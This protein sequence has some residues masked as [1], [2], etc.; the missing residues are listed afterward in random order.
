MS[1]VTVDL[2]DGALVFE[3]ERWGNAT[4]AV[5][6]ALGVA[7]GSGRRVLT[8][9]GFVV[10]TGQV[11][12]SVVVNG[13]HGVLGGEADAVLRVLA[14]FVDGESVLVWEDANGERWRYLFA[15]GLIEE[16]VPV[17]VW[18]GVGDRAVRAGGLLAPLTVTR[19]PQRYGQWWSELRPADADTIADGLIYL[20]LLSDIPL[21]LHDLFLTVFQQCFP[22]GAAWLNVEGLRR[23]WHVDYL[24]FDIDPTY[25]EDGACRGADVVLRVVVREQGREP[26]H[27]LAVTVSPR[28]LKDLVPDA[29]L[30]SAAGLA[31]IVDQLLL[32]VND[33]LNVRDRFTVC[34]RDV[35]Q[36]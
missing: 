26:A 23:G 10:D 32:L 24:T 17:V 25:G 20:Q 11:A 34:A 9:L 31:A 16:Q 6:Q 27:H 1:A 12:G 8:E 15:G 14:E 18:R 3:A 28:C 19:C 33:E 36:H 22:T 21:Q 13:F 4:V 5:E 2:M 35:P 7:A 29:D 30:D